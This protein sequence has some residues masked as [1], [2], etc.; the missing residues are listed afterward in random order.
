MSLAGVKVGFAVTSSHCTLEPVFK[1][2]KDLVDGGVEV[3]PIISPGVDKTNTRFGEAI[4]WKQKLVQMTGN[5]IINSIVSAEPI[6]PQGFIDVIVIAPCTG[7][8]IAKLANGITDTAVTMAAKAQIRNQKP[9]VISIS[10]NDA[11]G[12]NA[13]NIGTLLNS[14]YVYFVPFTQDNPINKPNSV[15]SHTDQIIPTIR[16]ALEGEQI[17]PLLTSREEQ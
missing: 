5:K 15:V 7:N 1:E 14:K 6:G 3:Y 12:L 9:V 11:L 2:I 4:E 13:R 16:K 10:T 8:T 17:Q